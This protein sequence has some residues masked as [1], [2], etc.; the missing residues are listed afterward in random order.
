MVEGVRQEDYAQLERTL[1]ALAAEY[2]AADPGRRKQVRAVVI[3]ARQHADWA[4][5]NPNATAVHRAEKDEMV[6][7]LRTWLENPPLFA[8]WLGLRKRVLDGSPADG[9]A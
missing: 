2:E 7:W 6:L 5:R 4:R 1:L 8:S 9:L 3:T